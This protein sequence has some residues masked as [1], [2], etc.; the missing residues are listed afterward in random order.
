MPSIFDNDSI[1]NQNN[2]TNSSTNAS[3]TSPELEQLRHI[4]QVLEDMLKESRSTS[5]QSVKDRMQSRDDFRNK[6]NKESSYKNSSNKSKKNSS[7]NGKFLDDM[8]DAF[9]KQM[10]AGIVGSDFDDRIKAIMD[11]FA[12]DIGVSVQ[13]I[14]KSIGEELGK[15]ATDALKNNDFIKN[16]MDKVNNNLKYFLLLCIILK[17]SVLKSSS[18]FALSNTVLFLH[19]SGCLLIAF[20]D[21]VLNK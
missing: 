8:E 17:N 6:Q 10:K 16:Q 21:V 13:D 18:V 4:A 9:W 12:S 19:F 14:P 11:Q 1:N 7:R 20:A 3:N 15:K 2:Q 5:Q